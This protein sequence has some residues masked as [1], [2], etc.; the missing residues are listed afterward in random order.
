MCGGIWIWAL[1]ATTQAASDLQPHTGRAIRLSDLQPHTSSLLVIVELVE[2]GGERLVIARSKLEVSH[3]SERVAAAE[4]DERWRGER[5]APNQE[6]ISRLFDTMVEA[7]CI[8][9]E[10]I[11]YYS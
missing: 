5:E 3:E 10:H 8:R 9:Y 7:D 4:F 11:N 2:E 6:G 1:T